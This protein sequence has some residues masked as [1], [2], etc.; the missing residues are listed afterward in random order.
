MKLKF[1]LPVLTLTM[2]FMAPQLTWAEEEV[3]MGKIGDGKR[4]WSVVKEGVFPGQTLE[5]AAGF[6]T[7]DAPN[8]A[9]DAA[10]V[11]IAVRVADPSSPGKA[12]KT[13]WLL[14]DQNPSPVAAVFHFHEG[15]GRADVETR[16]RMEQYSQV[17]AVAET[18]DGHFYMASH[19][20]KGAGACS[21]PPGKDQE[22]ALKNVGRM[23]MRLDNG[24]IRANQANG[25]EVMVSHP[26]NSGLAMDQVTHL[27]VPPY[28]VRQVQVSYAGRP[29]MTAE[30]DFSISENPVFHLYFLPHE[31]GELKAEILDTHNR[32][33]VQRLGVVLS[34]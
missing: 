9:E 16:I 4:E 8:R 1:C 33:F 10:V 12:V 17:R 27:Y 31:D 20:V 28:Y 29:V 21:A 14:V 18:M 26:N 7:L 23:K 13:L 22:A 32:Y 19:F 2:A 3:V 5:D 6:L 15:S 34:Q 30:V 25:V 24:P 11:P